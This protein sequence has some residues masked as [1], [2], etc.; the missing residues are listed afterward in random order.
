MAI[1]KEIVADALEKGEPDYNKNYSDGHVDCELPYIAMRGA[2]GAISDLAA[3]RASCPGGNALQIN[4]PFQDRKLE[5]TKPMRPAMV[6]TVFSALV[7]ELIHVRQC[8][9]HPGKYI[10]TVRRQAAMEDTDLDFAPDEW[11]EKYYGDELE[12]EAHA[13][14][15]AADVWSRGSTVEVADPY[16][17]WIRETE[18][19]RRVLR[20]LLPDTDGRNTEAAVWWQRLIETAASYEAS[21]RTSCAGTEATEVHC[22]GSP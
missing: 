21:W 16:G 4:M 3:I 5:S 7:H 18:I 2:K 15:L 20:R 9:D 14:Q 22:D 19:G 8:A 12:L 11:M 13:A 1:A 17:D 6:R 10:E